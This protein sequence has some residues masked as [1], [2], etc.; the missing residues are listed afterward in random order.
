VV[1][2]LR[3]AALFI[4]LFIAGHSCEC[5]QCTRKCDFV[6]TSNPR[7]KLEKSFIKKNSRVL[8]IL[9]MFNV[10]LQI[11]QHM[12]FFLLKINRSLKCPTYVSVG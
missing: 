8:L 12:H 2:R 6:I 1:P 11:H 10:M 9:C 5:M 3:R 7:T 4:C